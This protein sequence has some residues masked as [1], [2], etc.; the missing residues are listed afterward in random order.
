MSRSRA[1]S[2][3]AASLWAAALGIAAAAPGRAADLP[4]Y[5][6]VVVVEENKDFDQIIGNPAAPYINKLAAEGRVFTRMISGCFPA[7][8]RMSGSAT[9]CRP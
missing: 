2:P 4:R 3:G 6:H 7:A 9:R 1:G 8:T 5:D